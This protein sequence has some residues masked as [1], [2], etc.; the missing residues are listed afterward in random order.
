MP[1]GSRNSAVAASYLELALGQDPNNLDLRRHVFYLLMVE[2]Q[3]AAAAQHARAILQAEPS[4]F[5]PIITLAVLAMQEG[6]YES[7]LTRFGELGGGGHTGIMRALGQAWAAVGA[8]DLPAARAAMDFPLDAGGW[9]NIRAIHRAL[10]EDVGGGDPKAAYEALQEKPESLSPRLRLLIGNYEARQAKPETP[11]LIQDAN[12][13]LAQAFNTIAAALISAKQNQTGVIYTQM[14]LTLS[15]TD[16]GLLLLLAEP[17][18]EAGRFADAAA[19]YGKITPKS[20]YFYAAQI[21]KAR[22]LAEAEQFDQAVALL[23]TL[24]ADHADQANAPMVLGNLLRRK[25]QFEKAAAAYDMAFARLAST[26]TEPDWQLHYT[27]GIARERIGE[28]KLAEQDFLAAL[29]LEKDQPLVLNYLGYSWIDRGENLEKATAMVRKAADLRPDDGFIADSVGW[30]AYR[31]GNLG[32]A[33]RELE[34]AILIEPLDPTI[35]EHL[36]DVYWAIGRKTE[37]RYQ[38]D[39]ALS[40]EPEEERIPGLKERLACKDDPCAPL[41]QDGVRLAQ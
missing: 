7:A 15:P 17:L 38:W 23:E 14:G 22:N 35:N 41:E 12:E 8:G 5:L 24:T 36:G 31:T 3:L 37:A 10:I 9:E 6:D 39:R 19:V 13:G 28:W 26:A 29:A 11:P 2:G 20:S 4:A 40:F 16:D 25:L 21:A 33:V 32:E 34:R 1:S 27:R 18:Q 30:A